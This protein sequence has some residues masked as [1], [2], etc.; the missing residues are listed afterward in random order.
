[1]F[2]PEVMKKLMLDQEV[3]EKQLT[4]AIQRYGL[5]SRVVKMWQEQLDILNKSSKKMS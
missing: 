5:Q 3:M 2:T 1:M 4:H